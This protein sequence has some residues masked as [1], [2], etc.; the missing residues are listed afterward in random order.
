MEKTTVKIQNQLR[1]ISKELINNN[2]SDGINILMGITGSIDLSEMTQ[3]QFNGLLNI[4]NISEKNSSPKKKKLIPQSQSGNYGFKVTNSTLESLH[5]V[6]EKVPHN[7]LEYL[8][9][10][11]LGYKSNYQLNKLGQKG[12]LEFQKNG[13]KIFVQSDSKNNRKNLVKYLFS[14]S[15]SEILKKGNTNSNKGVSVGELKD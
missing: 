5:N 12:L 1:S 3:T 11:E 15:Q 9:V 6:C 13:G 4:F 2:D 7:P 14:K 8:T 10:S